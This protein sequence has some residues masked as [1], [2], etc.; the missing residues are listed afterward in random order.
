MNDPDGIAL[1]LIIGI[2]GLAFLAIAALVQY[3]NRTPWR[4]D[5]WDR[6]AARKRRLDRLG[7]NQRMG[8]R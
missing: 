3:V 6:L 5:D 4:V 7:R 2:A 8:I 1:A